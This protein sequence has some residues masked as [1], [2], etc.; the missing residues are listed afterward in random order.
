MGLG[1]LGGGEGEEWGERGRNCL[2]AQ[3]VDV[4]LFTSTA[5]V[6]CFNAI[7]PGRRV[8]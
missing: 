6:K 5:S 7:L 4:S 2:V 1:S 3:S 8:L